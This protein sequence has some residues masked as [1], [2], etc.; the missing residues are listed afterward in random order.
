MDETAADST[1]LIENSSVQKLSEQT[2]VQVPE[3]PFCA[4]NDNLHR[5][6]PSVTW[7][8]A[9]YPSFNSIFHRQ[10][11]SHFTILTICVGE[12]VNKFFMEKVVSIL[13]ETTIEAKR[14]C[15]IS[16]VSSHQD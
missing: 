10:E 3:T 8:T 15:A 1:P 4:S 12:V 7:S 16:L 14:S 13:H 5:R 2:I 6:T 11:H 9:N